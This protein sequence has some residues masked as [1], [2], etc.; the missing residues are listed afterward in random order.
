MEGLAQGAA[1]MGRAEFGPEEG[2]QGVAPM[3][4][5]WNRRGEIDEKGGTLGLAGE[6]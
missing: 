2:E 1:R 6:G 5:L 4:A 3:E